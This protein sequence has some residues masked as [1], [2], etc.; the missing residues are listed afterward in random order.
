[1]QIVN[2]FTDKDVSI[3]ENL[4]NTSVS[5]TWLILS[6]TL[7]YTYQMKSSQIILELDDLY[8]INCMYRLS[9]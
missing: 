3:P 8:L 2:S 6:P 7:E 1:M 5:I 4:N 9:K